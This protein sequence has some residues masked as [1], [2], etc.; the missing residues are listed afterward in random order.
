MLMPKREKRRRVHR[1]RMKGK[2]T[3][4]NN[5]TY[6]HFALVA[7]EPAWITGNQIESA[8][9]AMNRYMKRGGRVFI[10]IF[11]HKP[12]TKKPA[13]VRMGSGKGSP[14]YHVAVVKPGRVLF[15]I[16]DVSLEVA[17]EAMRL[18]SYKLPIK[19]KFVVKDGW[20]EALKL[21]AKKPVRI[22]EEPKKA[23]TE[24]AE[25]KPEDA[26]KDDD[27]GAENQNKDQE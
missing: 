20:E 6:G 24:E 18:A 16:G 10:N 5:I 25:A 22:I 4:G 13:E 7:K 3:R 19:T 12:V 21:A 15:E 27:K 26:P 17:K 11:P 9:I 8:R 2:A 23:D 14:E 1:G